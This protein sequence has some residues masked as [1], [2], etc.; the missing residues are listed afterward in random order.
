M[1]KAE[2]DPALFYYVKNEKLV[3]ILA[4]HVD[5]ALYVGSAEF[6]KDVIK[7]M[8]AGQIQRRKSCRG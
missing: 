1:T 3:G 6:D 4:L 2:T 5:D 8:M 7:P